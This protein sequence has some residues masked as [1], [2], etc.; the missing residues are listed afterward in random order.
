MLYNFQELVAF[1]ACLGGHK[2]AFCSHVCLFVIFC[3]AE[4]GKK[5]N[6]DILFCS[7]D[8]LAGVLHNKIVNCVKAC[9]TCHH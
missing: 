7:C 9:L 2:V 4:M 6:N 1:F 8:V 5:L 3:V